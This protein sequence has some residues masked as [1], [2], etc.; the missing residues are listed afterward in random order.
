MAAADYDRDGRVDLYLCCY[1]YFQSEDQY[2]YPA[3]Y[4]D[5]QNGPPNFLF[6]NQLAAEGG[7]FF[8]D[9][10]A[11]V[12]LNENNDRYSFA[13]AWC[14]YDGDGWPDL[15]RRQRFRP[16]ESLQEYRRA[17]SRRRRSRG[18]GGHR[19]GHERR[20]VRLRRRR[21]TRPLRQ[22]YVDRVR[23]A[24]GRRSALRSGGQGRA[25]RS[26]PAAHQGQ[27]ALSQ[28]RRRDLRGNRSAGA[29]RDGPVGVVGRRLRFRQRRRPG[30][31]CRLRHAH[32]FVGEGRHELFLAA[33]GGE[34]ARRRKRRRR[35]TRTDGTPS[36]S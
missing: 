15:L 21:A 6:R 35:P 10:T 16:E 28:S 20:V 8:E 29:R 30:D 11:A 31:L 33:G 2:R 9:V 17:F 22:Q 12:G 19:A 13:P 25:R 1:V 23:A 5:A 4:H 34:F 24:A 7:G 36:I 18:R 3:P 14:D 26:L 32:Q 27:F